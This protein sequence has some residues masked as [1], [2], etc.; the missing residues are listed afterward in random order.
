MAGNSRPKEL[1]EQPPV[2]GIGCLTRILW[3]IVGNMVLLFSVSFIVRGHYASFSGADMVF[4][5]TVGLLVLLR[6]ADIARFH[7][8][9]AQGHQPA[10]MAHWRRYAVWLVAMAALLWFLAHGI[11]YL[12]G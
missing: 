1:H 3:M 4:W 12:I 8:T 5:I 9:T 6:Y 11:A 2:G 7:G 10:T